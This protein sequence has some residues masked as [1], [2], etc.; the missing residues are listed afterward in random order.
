MSNP[1]EWQSADIKPDDE[2][3]VE[4]RTKRKRIER[5]WW[6]GVGWKC[7]PGMWVEDQV[8]AWR[9]VPVEGGR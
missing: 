4:V 7:G 6:K 1:R 5:A 9:E 3:V 2:R 8:I